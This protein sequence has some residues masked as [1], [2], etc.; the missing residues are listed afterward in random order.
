MTVYETD[1]SVNRCF[2]QCCTLNLCILGIRDCL[3]CVPVHF[4]DEKAK[5]A[6]AP[7]QPPIRW[8]DCETLSEL[9]M[10]LKI[11]LPKYRMM[12][13]I[14]V[15][16]ISFSLKEVMEARMMKANTTPEAPNNVL[17]VNTLLMIAVTTAVAPMTNR[18]RSLPYFSSNMGPKRMN[19]SMLL[20]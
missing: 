18:M 3:R 19:R 14:K 20:M 8:A 12:T 6:I 7:Q 17:L 11:S 9:N 5:P 10:P 16:G 1:D 4:L 13:R 15:N 2:I